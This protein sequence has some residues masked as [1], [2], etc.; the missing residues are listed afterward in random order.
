MHRF[1]GIKNKQ[2]LFGKCGGFLRALAVQKDHGISNAS[3][4]F[5]SVLIWCLCSSTK[6]ENASVWG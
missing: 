3:F 2:V 1:F 5:N 4:N 6:Q